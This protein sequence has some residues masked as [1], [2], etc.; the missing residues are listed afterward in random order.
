MAFQLPEYREPDFA[1][2]SLSTAPDA[3]FEPAPADGVAPA[4]FHSTSM[5]PEYVKM[6]G[7][8]RLV[9]EIRM[10]SCIVRDVIGGLSAVEARHLRAGDAVCVGRVDDGSQGILVH[11]YG[12]AQPA[13]VRGDAFSFRQSRSRETAFSCD[14]DRLFDL[15]R[16]DREH[17]SIV[18]VMGPAC[19]FDHD[20]RRALCA[21]IDAGYVHGVLAGN[22][23]ATHDLEA[24]LFNTAL[25][26]DIYTQR[27]APGGHYNHLDA[28]NEV[29]R[30]GSIEAFV[31][32]RGIQDGI[33]AALVRNAV[34]YVLTGSIR[35]DGPL[36]DVIPNVY[37]GQAAM[38]A[39]VRGA[40]TIICMAT[41]LH[42][43]AT[44]NLAPS[45]RVMPDG[46][47]RPVYLYTIDMSEFVVN[48]LADRGS[49]SSTSIVANVQDFAT[50]VARGLGAME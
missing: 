25:G 35:D 46:S 7:V 44:G 43:I 3:R 32:Q 16:H 13:S 28:I 36:P 45:Y 4:G 15:L 49:L 31:R 18:W 21:L 48:K 1:A 9:P 30:A 47:V 14:Y 6:D 5:Y 8:W 38:R 10:D 42:T 26:Q 2:Q 17:G 41:M 40:T 50:L 23:L 19:T 37:D 22:A 20:A 39:Q 24:A 34:P 33:M 12:F 29:C 11:P 27:S